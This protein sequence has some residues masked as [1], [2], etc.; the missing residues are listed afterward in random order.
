MAYSLPKGTKVLT[1]KSGKGPDAPDREMW[2]FKAGPNNPHA[3]TPGMA[4]TLGPK[5]DAYLAKSARATVPHPSAAEFPGAVP[6]SAPRIERVFKVPL[7]TPKW[8]ST[9]LYAPPGEILRIQVSAELKGASVIIGCHRDN[10]LGSK[11]ERTHR[12]PRISLSRTFDK[13]NIEVA[14]P[15]G[16]LIYIDVPDK[17]EWEKSRGKARVEIEGGVEAPYFRLGETTPEEWLRLRQA[18]APWAEF[19]GEKLIGSVPSDFVRKLDY[20]TMKELSEYWDKAV[21]LQ[22]WLAGWGPRRAPERFV[23]DAEL[24]AGYGHSGY[25]YMGYLDWGSGFVDLQSLKTS[26][27]WGHFHEMGH[28]HMS[29]I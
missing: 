4:V 27:S 2:E 10:I 17:K 21:E 12:F 6:E 22:D 13:Q 15:F 20:A 26:G 11:R 25:P 23:A 5:V 29:R 19:G 28:S 8:F 14:S 1:P 16:G 18:P 24:S 9:G 7:C 3:L